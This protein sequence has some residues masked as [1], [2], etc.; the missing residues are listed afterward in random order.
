[1]PK[2]PN[3]VVPAAAEPSPPPPPAAPAPAPRPDL[4]ARRAEI[5]RRAQSIDGEDPFQILGVG[6]DASYQEIRNAYFALARTW[7]PHRLPPDLAD[8]KPS[9]SRIFARVNEAY[10]ILNDAEKRKAY[11]AE[12]KQGKVEEEAKIARVV[13]AALELQ[14][15]EILLKKNDLAGA[16]ALAA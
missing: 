13:D 2:V 16:E 3:I 5:E 8:L 15:A 10:Q 9:V 4:A 14:K 1:K 11:I 6:R 12:Q 7:H